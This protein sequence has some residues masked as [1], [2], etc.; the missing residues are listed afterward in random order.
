MTC[1]S[2]SEHTSLQLF[3]FLNYPLTRICFLKKY[4]TFLLFLLCMAR[5]KVLYERNGKCSDSRKGSIIS[6]LFLITGTIDNT[7]VYRNK[8]VYAFKIEKEQF[9]IKQP[10]AQF[11]NND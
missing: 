11:S 4:N 1:Y 6:L 7:A 8:T 9:F 2:D 10:Q 3:L 5:I